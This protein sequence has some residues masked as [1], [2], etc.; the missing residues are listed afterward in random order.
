MTAAPYVPSPY[1]PGWEIW[2]G[3]IA[4][5]IPFAIGSYEFGKRIVSCRTSCNSH[6]RIAWLAHSVPPLN[7][8]TLGCCACLRPQLIQLRCELC[9][10]KGLVPSTNAGKWCLWSKQGQHWSCSSHD[11]C[12]RC[13]VW[14]Y[15]SHAQHH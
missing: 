3:A 7:G 10:G 11:T 1:E 15:L 14:T 4:G 6:P 5:I 13:R 2:A 8:T 9:A 12:A